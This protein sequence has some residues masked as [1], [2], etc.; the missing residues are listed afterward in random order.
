M[1]QR[2]GIWPF[3]ISD[4]HIEHH[5][6]FLPVQWI[7]WH[8][9]L[10]P[11]VYKKCVK[12]PSRL[13]WA[14]SRLWGNSAGQMRVITVCGGKQKSFIYLLLTVEKMETGALPGV[15]QQAPASLPWVTS[16]FPPEACIPQAA[17]N[18][19]L[20]DSFLPEPW[21]PALWGSCSSTR[22][23]SAAPLTLNFFPTVS[24]LRGKGSESEKLD[25]YRRKE[26]ERAGKRPAGIRGNSQLRKET[27]GELPNSL[28]C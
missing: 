25:S 17:V 15:T 6:D 9:H 21:L 10:Q 18:S 14:N 8:F 26:S 7:Q 4:R 16:F 13:Q 23:E 19:C 27:H 24:I 1:P 3:F 20:G 28:L 12:W 22:H 11:L 5:W 2:Q